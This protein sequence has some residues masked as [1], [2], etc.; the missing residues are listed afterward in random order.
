MLSRKHGTR[1]PS[2]GPSPTA[3]PALDPIPVL[4]SAA[5][6][7]RSGDFSNYFQSRWNPAAH[8]TQTQ[9]PSA[10]MAAPPQGTCL[11]SWAEEQPVPGFQGSRDHGAEREREQGHVLT[12]REP[13]FLIQALAALHQHIHHGQHV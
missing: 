10:P 2:R 1:I 11:A 4:S 6:S 7:S 12:Q 5:G 8:P 3:R 13:D 9:L